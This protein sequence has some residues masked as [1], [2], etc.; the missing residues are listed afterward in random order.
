MIGLYFIN[1]DKNVVLVLAAAQ[2]AT[3]IVM[4]SK[5]PQRQRR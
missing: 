5:L 2:A 1:N 4:L 3:P